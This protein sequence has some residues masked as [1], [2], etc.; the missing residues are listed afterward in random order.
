MRAAAKGKCMAKKGIPRLFTPGICGVI[1]SYAA[2][3]LFNAR[4]FPD[5]LNAV[6]VTPNN[7]S[8]RQYEP[9]LGSSPR[10]RNGLR[11]C[12]TMGLPLSSSGT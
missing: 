4:A 11:Q 8:D 6:L 7:L 10:V 12:T 2:P 3:S 9:G 1:S 5:D